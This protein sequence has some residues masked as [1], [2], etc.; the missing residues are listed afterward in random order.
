MGKKTHCMHPQ[1]YIPYERH[2]KPR[3]VYFLPTFWSPKTFFQGA[4]CLKI[5][6]LCMVSIQERFLI[7]SG[8]WWP[9][10]SILLYMTGTRNTWTT[11]TWFFSFMLAIFE[12]TDYITFWMNWL[13][14]WGQNKSHWI[15]KAPNKIWPWTP[16]DH[17]EKENV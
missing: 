11:K 1:F 8:L 6:T 17:I 9:A 16:S 13:I 12:K 14:G 2:Y 7:N 3:F 5:L 15:L 4:F 10:Y